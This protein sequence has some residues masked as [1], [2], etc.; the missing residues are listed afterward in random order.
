VPD[1]G[2]DFPRAVQNELSL[3]A[4]LRCSNP[5]CRVL[6]K[7][8]VGI[9]AGV[10]SIGV[11]AHIRAS[12][13]GG[14]RYDPNQT[15]AERASATNGIWLCNNCSRL[16]DGDPKRYAPELL[17]GWKLRHE[18]EVGRSIGRAPEDP[19]RITELPVENRYLDGKGIRAA[20]EAEGFVVKVLA[21]FEANT[22]V[23]LGEAEFIADPDTEQGPV[24]LTAGNYYGEDLIYVAERRR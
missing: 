14:P 8:S 6:T 21:R 10:L 16:I 7:G 24:R 4:G 2:D 19:V 23:G 13:R 3:R 9:A 1:A 17:Q 5:S 22:K 18:E 12:R 15:S 20:L 11:A